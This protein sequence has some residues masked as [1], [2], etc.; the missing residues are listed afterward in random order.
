MNPN[1]H[2]FLKTVRIEQ[3]LSIQELSKLSGVSASHISRIERYNRK[4][5]PRTLE[6]LAPHLNVTYMTL[7][8][9]ANLVHKTASETIHMDEVL[10]HPHLVFEGS[11]VSEEVRKQITLLLENAKK[12]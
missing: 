10:K 8:E 3:Q 9:V 11:V 5:S 1:I 6:K 4:P 2:D 7:L 12:D